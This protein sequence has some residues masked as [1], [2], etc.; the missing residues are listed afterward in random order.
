M[1]LFSTVTQVFTEGRPLYYISSSHKLLKALETSWCKVVGVFTVLSSWG[2][3]S[4]PKLKDEL[5]KCWWAIS[6]EIAFWSH[7]V[8]FGAQAV[9]KNHAW[10][11]RHSRECSR[12]P[13]H[14][15]L[16][17]ATGSHIGF[18]A[19]GTWASEGP[20]AAVKSPHPGKSASSLRERPVQVQTE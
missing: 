9:T 16:E 7:Q 17:P 5:I 13:P 20:P 8:G 6:D 3:V 11:K 1:L 15:F 18:I 4:E 12:P 14:H 10:V 2:P 19:Y